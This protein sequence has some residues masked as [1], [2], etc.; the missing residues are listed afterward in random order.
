M[1]VTQTQL[2]AIRFRVASLDPV[3]LVWLGFLH[4]MFKMGCKNI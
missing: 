1:T 2:A 3:D 4:V